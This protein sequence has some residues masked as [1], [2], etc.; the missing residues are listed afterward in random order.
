M[1]PATEEQVR[2]LERIIVTSSVGTA[3]GKQAMLF[4][5]RG[6]AL[7]TQGVVLVG[8]EKF[9]EIVTTVSD[10]ISAIKAT[11]INKVIEGMGLKF[12]F[13]FG[14]KG[15]LVFDHRAKLFPHLFSGE[16]KE[17]RSVAALEV[18]VIKSEIEKISLI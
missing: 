1:K 9:T 4:A 15:G 6:S 16:A 13:E 14:S 18:K 8:K 10:M 11:R 3:Y 5:L 17:A 2:D 12:Y 7:L